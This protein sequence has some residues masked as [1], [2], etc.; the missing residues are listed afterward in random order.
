MIASQND[1]DIEMKPV[2]I[3][4]RRVF[5]CL[6]AVLAGAAAGEERR[7][8]GEKCRGIRVIP[9]RFPMRQGLQSLQR[10]QSPQSSISG[11]CRW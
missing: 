5:L 8:I 2:G 7:G 10:F 4:S 3:D 11:L 9:M 1:R 6:N